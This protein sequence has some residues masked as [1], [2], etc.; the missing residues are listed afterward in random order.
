VL[1][2]AGNGE[3]GQLGH[4]DNRSRIAAR[5]RKIMAL[6]GRRIIRVGCGGAH[7]AAVVSTGAIYA[8]GRGR[9]GRLGHG[10]TKKQD[11]PRQVIGLRQQR[12]VGVA[13]GWNF[14][15]A[16]AEDAVFAWGKNAGGQC[17]CGAG[18]KLKDRHVPVSVAIQLTHTAEERAHVVTVSCGYTHALLVCSNGDLYSWGQGEYGQLGREGGGS[19]P[20]PVPGLVS[21]PP[22]TSIAGAYCGA[23]HSVALCQR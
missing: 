8:W 17:G 14:T 11:T 22:S 10:D 21:V 16:H 12:V 9:N 5:P 18:D 3:D 23:F 15:I 19:L 20:Q 1:H 13:C 2:G 6:L 4:G 7:T